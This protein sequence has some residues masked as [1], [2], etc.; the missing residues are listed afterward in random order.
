MPFST[1]GG[2]AAVPLLVLVVLTYTTG[3]LNRAWRRTLAELSSQRV[4]QEGLESVPAVMSS[5]P[6]HSR[7]QRSTTSLEV[8]HE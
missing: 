5:G 6:S 3:P 2:E 1:P 7:D 4:A 8:S